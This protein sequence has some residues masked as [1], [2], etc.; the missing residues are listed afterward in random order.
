[1][2]VGKAQRDA[3]GEHAWNSGRMLPVALSYR[4]AIGNILKDNVALVSVDTVIHVQV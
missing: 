2:L 3:V 4:S 1:M